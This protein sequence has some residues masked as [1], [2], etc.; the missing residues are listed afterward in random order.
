MTDH[1]HFRFLL[2]Y[3]PTATSPALALV[4]SGSDPILPQWLEQLDKLKEAGEDVAF[5]Y[6]EFKG[7]GC[8]LH[9]LSDRMG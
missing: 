4:S 6:G 2:H 8:V 3:S 7:K 5:G 1:R 9:Y